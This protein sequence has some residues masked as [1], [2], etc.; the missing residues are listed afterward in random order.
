MSSRLLPRS[1]SF[2]SGGGFNLQTVSGHLKP[3]AASNALVSRSAL[4]TRS[5]ATPPV[6]PTW[7][8]A[9]W[10]LRQQPHGRSHLSEGGLTLFPTLAMFVEIGLFN[11]LAGYIVLRQDVSLAAPRVVEES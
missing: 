5:R 8:T 4:A 2:P 10:Y 9:S 6:W 3:A 1:L 7:T 11:D